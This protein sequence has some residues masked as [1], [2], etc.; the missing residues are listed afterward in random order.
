MFPIHCQ[1]GMTIGGQVPPFARVQIEQRGRVYIT[2]PRQ[3]SVR[4][5]N[6]NAPAFRRAIDIVP[7]PRIR[8][9]QGLQCVAIW[10]RQR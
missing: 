10:A 2:G 3:G 7:S 9:S 6:I 4:R 1:A 8:G 5:M